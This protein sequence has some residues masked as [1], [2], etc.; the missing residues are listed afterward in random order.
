MAPLFG[1]LAGAGASQPASV[2]AAPAYSPAAAY[3]GAAAYINGLVSMT[4]QRWPIWPGPPGRTVNSPIPPNPSP[5][6][7]VGAQYTHPDRLFGPFASFGAG[8]GGFSGL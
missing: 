6:G 1:P 3:P 5:A 8:A 4:R 7:M 2:Y